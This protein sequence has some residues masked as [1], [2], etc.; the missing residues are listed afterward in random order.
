[1]ANIT[2]CQRHRQMPIGNGMGVKATSKVQKATSGYL[3]QQFLLPPWNCFHNYWP[4]HLFWSRTQMLVLWPIDKNKTNTSSG[5]NKG[6][7]FVCSSWT[8]AIPW[9]FRHGEER[10]LLCKGGRA[11]YLQ[12]E[13]IQ[14]NVNMLITFAWVLQLVDCFEL[15]QAAIKIQTEEVYPEHAC[16]VQGQR[17][18]IQ[19]YIQVW[20]RN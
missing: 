4:V 6:G 2:G 3:N 8:P 13:A 11:W 15:L 20:A 18:T 5:Q 10:T 14:S 17:Q 19:L 16:C 1:M 9:Y 7:G 12:L